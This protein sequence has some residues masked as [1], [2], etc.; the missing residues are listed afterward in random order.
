MLY[1]RKT[2]EITQRVTSYGIQMK[3]KK[4]QKKA[5]NIRCTHAHVTTL[6]RERVCSLSPCRPTV[7]Q[8]KKHSSFFT[9]ISD[10]LGCRAKGRSVVSDLTWL[11][12]FTD[13]CTLTLTAGSHFFF[14]HLNRCVFF[15]S[16]RKKKKKNTQSCFRN[17]V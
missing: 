3:H 7:H 1:E 9:I 16:V 11:L 5:L 14:L 6:A 10:I 4:I 8:K 13:I 2:D 15:F 12:N 17:F